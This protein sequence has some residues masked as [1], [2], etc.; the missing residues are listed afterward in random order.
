MLIAPVIHDRPSRLVLVVVASLLLGST[1][2]SDEPKAESA[3]LQFPND[4]KPGDV[5]ISLTDVTR[6]RGD[7]KESSHWDLRLRIT[8]TSDRKLGLWR[9][10]GN[11]DREFDQ[12]LAF[13]WTDAKGRAI[14]LQSYRCRPILSARVIA[15]PKGFVDWTITY[16]INQDVVNPGVRNIVKE[17]ASKLEGGAALPLRFRAVAYGPIAVEADSIGEHADSGRLLESYKQTTAAKEKGLPIP[18]YVPTI[19][20]SSDWIDVEESKGQTESK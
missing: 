6:D 20:A 3:T 2:L 7:G 4:A 14:H 5:S 15:P 16:R 8:N 11:G 18:K 1:S 9:G 12:K 19:V 17:R 10:P 13:E